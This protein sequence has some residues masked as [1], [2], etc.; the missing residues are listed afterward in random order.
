[1]TE[2][3]FRDQMKIN[4]KR[5]WH[6]EETTNSIQN[7]TNWFIYEWNVLTVFQSFFIIQFQFFAGAQFKLSRCKLLWLTETEMKVF[8]FSFLFHFHWKSFM[9]FIYTSQKYKWGIRTLCDYA[10]ENSD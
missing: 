6:H 8:F 4:K 7:R 9:I 5:Q 2:K 10:R 1:M 3:Q